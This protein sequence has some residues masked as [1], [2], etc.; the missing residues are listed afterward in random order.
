MD[1]ASVT[2]VSLWQGRKGTS[3]SGGS[4]EQMPITFQ[5]LARNDAADTILLEQLW[6]VETC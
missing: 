3:N 4:R 1:V 6:L 2:V 5:F